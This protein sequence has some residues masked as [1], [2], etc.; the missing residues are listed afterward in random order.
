MDE[1]IES[2]L[3][4]MQDQIEQLQTVI[5]E[6]LPYKETVEIISNKLA[7][8]THIEFQAKQLHALEVGNPNM[9]IDML[10][11]G[12]EAYMYACKTIESKIQLIQLALET[13]DPQIIL[14]VSIFLYNSLDIEY[15]NILVMS[16]NFASKEYLLNRS[17][18]EFKIVCQRYDRI[19]DLNRELLK[20][21]LT[22]DSVLLNYRETRYY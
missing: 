11:K 14:S 20:R 22:D 18:E 10:R 8:L 4:S 13:R 7:T 16:N 15:F 5:D 6:L 21:N 19:H 2:K 3:Q 9:A 1:I 12:H 17:F